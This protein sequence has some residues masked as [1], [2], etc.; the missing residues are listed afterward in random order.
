MIEVE[1]EQLWLPSVT[2]QLLPE[3]NPDSVNVTGE[4]KTKFAVTVPA[5]LTVTV[6]LKHDEQ[7][8]ARLP[9]ADHELNW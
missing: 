4:I 7:L 1:V 3:G 6:V 8:T 5:P 2:H 9:L